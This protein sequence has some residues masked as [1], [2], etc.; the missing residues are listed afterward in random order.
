MKLA[1]TTHGLVSRAWIGRDL[2]C[3]VCFDQMSPL[4]MNLNKHVIEHRCD[5]SKKLIWIIMWFSMVIFFLYPHEICIGPNTNPLYFRW[6]TFQCAAAPLD[7]L[8][9]LS[10]AVCKYLLAKS[11]SRKPSSVQ[12]CTHTHTTTWWEREDCRLYSDCFYSNFTSGNCAFMF[13]K[14][15]IQTP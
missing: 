3:F 1:N 13:Q 8:A 10:S 6:R 15:D 2:F 12:G 9:A 14:Y 11:L 5:F 4:F 7:A